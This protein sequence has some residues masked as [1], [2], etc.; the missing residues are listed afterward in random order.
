MTAQQDGIFYNEKILTIATNKGWAGF[1]L[2]GYQLS[3]A[4]YTIRYQTHDSQYLWVL[5]LENRYYKDYSKERNLQAVLCIFSII[6]GNWNQTYVQVNDQVSLGLMP[7]LFL[8]LANSYLQM[9]IT[10]AKNT[11]IYWISCLQEHH[12]HLV[13]F[14][15]DFTTTDTRYYQTARFYWILV[16]ISCIPTINS[17]YRNLTYSRLKCRSFLQQRKNRCAKI[18]IFAILLAQIA[19]LS[20][21]IIDST[22]FPI[23]R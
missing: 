14:R 7:E 18:L 6:I 16:L 12:H 17:Q 23:Y 9:L 20:G 3:T 21:Q 22:C 8:Y 10:H 2:T 1:Q 5:T 13:N 15:Q 11:Y 19:G 4:W